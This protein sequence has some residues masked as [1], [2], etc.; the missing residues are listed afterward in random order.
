MRKDKEAG[1]ERWK[2]W[3]KIEMGGRRERRKEE[4]KEN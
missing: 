2:K 1:S 4:R 3:I